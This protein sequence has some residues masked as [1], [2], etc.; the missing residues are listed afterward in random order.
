M[1]PNMNLLESTIICCY[2]HS[3]PLTG[4]RM[5]RPY[6]GKVYCYAR[7]EGTRS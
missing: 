1:P 2:S 7:A 5:L 3:F 4:R 6:K